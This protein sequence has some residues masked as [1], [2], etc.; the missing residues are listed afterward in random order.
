METPGKASS[1]QKVVT[2]ILATGIEQDVFSAAQAAWC[3]MDSSPVV[4]ST[5]LTQKDHGVLVTGKTLFDI[6]S[7]TK[8]FVASVAL[9]LIDRK[10]I[11]LDDKLEDHLP[12]LV[13]RKTG[14]AS[15]AE[16]L[17][18]EAGFVSWLPLFEE[19]DRKQRGTSSAREKMISAALTASNQLVP[20]TEAVYS[21]L[22][23]IALTALVERVSGQSLAELVEAEVTGVLGLDSTSFFLDNHMTIPSPQIA[24]TEDCPWRGRLLVGEV[25]DDNAW[26]MGGVSGHAGLFA[27]AADVARFGRAWLRAL[28][29]RGWLPI[30]LVRQATTRRSLGRGL[31]WDLKKAKGSSAG[32]LMSESSFGHLGFTGCS[33]WVDPRRE[34]SVALLTNRVHFGRDNLSIRDFRPVFHDLLVECFDAGN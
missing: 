8:V 4:V 31:G 14:T 30:D 17:S 16:L 22:G 9:R 26:T 19:L 25:H 21:D 13:G 24:A 15:L 1:L 12:E 27:D 7:L 10:E 11:N 33:L 29:G 32:S 20:G 28:K 23:F 5:G 2:Q 34:L 3:E 6:A 18:H